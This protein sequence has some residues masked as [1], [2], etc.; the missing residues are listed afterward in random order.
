MDRGN[1]SFNIIGEFD[2][3]FTSFIIRDISRSCSCFFILKFKNKSLFYGKILTVQ[4]TT[5]S[6]FLRAVFI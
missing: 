5:R 3:L 1:K 6:C 4:Q 2:W